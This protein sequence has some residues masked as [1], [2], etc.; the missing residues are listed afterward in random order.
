[1]TGRLDGRVAVVTGSARGIGKGIAARFA[2]EGARVLLVDIR[3]DDLEAAL[4]DMPAEHC[5]MLA[6]DLT[7]RAA[8]ERVV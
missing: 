3:A 1:M 6:I 2:E 8:P 5:A 7:D 4:E